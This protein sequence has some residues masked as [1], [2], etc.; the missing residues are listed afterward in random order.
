MPQPA[1]ADIEVAALGPAA[2]LKLDDDGVIVFIRYPQAR[3]ALTPAADRRERRL[4]GWQT[5]ETPLD[6]RDDHAGRNAQ[7]RL[8]PNFFG[9]YHGSYFHIGQFDAGRKCVGANQ[10]PFKPR[11]RNG[12]LQRMDYLQQCRIQLRR[13]N[14]PS[15][16]ALGHILFLDVRREAG[17]S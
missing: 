1:G 8:H 9:L 17:R 14:Q 16:S 4:G 15:P 3:L 5:C 12:Q 2:R 7:R 6:V 11:W 10:C 13:S